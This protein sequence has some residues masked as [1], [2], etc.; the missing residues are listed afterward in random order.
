MAA[1]RR[2]AGR[3]AQLSTSEGQAEASQAALSGVPEAGVPPTRQ[4]GP[5]SATGQ[6]VRQALGL[7]EIPK[8]KDRGA[9]DA[10]KVGEPLKAKPQGLQK[11]QALF[12]SNGEVD[13]RL[14]PTASGPQSAPAATHAEG[15]KRIQER[16]DA[17]QDYIEARS[18]QRDKRLSEATISRLG[19]AELRA[20]ASQRGYKDIPEHGNRT[21]RTWFARQQEEDEALGKDEL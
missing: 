14:V 5:G 1:K 18:T 11:E 8:G 21:T 10:P 13:L 12:T 16:R 7:E 17:H 19:H 15:E 4:G 2:S 9:P 20:I 3:R 6:A